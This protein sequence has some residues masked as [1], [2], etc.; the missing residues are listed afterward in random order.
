M[1]IV[2]YSVPYDYR[3]H[4]EHRSKKNKKNIGGRDGRLWKL[5]RKRML[6]ELRLKDLEN[7]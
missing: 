3:P 6:E 5:R 4:R 1:V 2:R 7:N